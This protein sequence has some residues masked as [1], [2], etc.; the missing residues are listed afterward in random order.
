MCLSCC[1]IVAGL[2][3]RLG[4][5]FCKTIGPTNPMTIR[6][7]SMAFWPLGYGVILSDGIISILFCHCSHWSKRLHIT[8]IN[9]SLTSFLNTYS[10]QLFICVGDR[11]TTPNHGGRNAQHGIHAA[12]HQ[13]DEGSTMDGHRSSRS[14]SRTQAPDH[15]ARRRH[16]PNNPL[17][18]L[19]FRH[20]SLR[21]RAERRNGKR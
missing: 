18:D 13:N 16:R 17:H 6:G 7:N 21:R 11:Q 9:S 12:S 2:K 3:F 4:R 19:R 15:R 20:P 10:F 8:S 5:L 14:G 1:V